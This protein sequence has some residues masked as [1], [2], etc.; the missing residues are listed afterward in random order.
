M[1]LKDTLELIISAD[2]KGAV[3][4]FEEVGASAEK[5]LSK[6][7]SGADRLGASMQKAGGLMIG[8]GAVAV[9]AFG[10]L[11]SEGEKA[12]Q[13]QLKLEQ[14]VQKAGDAAGGSVQPFEDLSHAIADKTEFDHLSVASSEAMQLQVGLTKDQVLKLTPAIADLAAKNGIDLATATDKVTKAVNG[15]K[16]GLESLLG[17]LDAATYATDRYAAV[18]AALDAKVGGFAE[19]QGKTFSGQL[20]IMKN[21]LKDLEEGVGQGAVKAFSSLF[22]AVDTVTGA[23][24]SL[25]PGLQSTIGEWGTFAAVGLVGVGVLTTV[26]GTVMKSVSTLG[27]LAQ[28]LG[29][30]RTAKVA[31]IAVTEAETVANEEMAASM[32]LTPWGMVAIGV[33][34]VAGAFAL[35]SGNAEHFNVD[36]KKMA[37][38]SDGD[39]AASLQ[40]INVVMSMTGTSAYDMGKQLAEQ[41]IPQAERLVTVFGATTEK[42]QAVAR[43]IADVKAEHIKSAE[44]TAIDKQ[45]TDDAT[46]AAQ[47]LNEAEIN[48]VDSIKAKDDALKAELDPLFA[49]I[50]ASNTIMKSHLDVAAAQDKV[51]EAIKKYGAKSPEAVAAQNALNDAQYSGV[52]AAEHFELTL[53]S[54]KTAVASGSVPLTDAKGKLQEWVAE[55]L[56]TQDQAN[57][58]ADAFKAVG[59][60]AGL[61]DGKDV[62]MT[63]STT[64]KNYGAVSGSAS[65]VQTGARAGGGPT[66]AGGFYEVNEYS[67][68]L[69]ETGGHTYLMMGSKGGNVVP[70]GGMSGRGSGG[71]VINLTVNAGMGSDAQQIVDAIRKAIRTTGGA[72]DVQALLGAA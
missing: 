17:P 23:L 11:A 32:A 43:S 28:T 46:L 4:G 48:L 40:K 39:L 24:D 47:G 49:A 22:G 67:P 52:K 72:R 34:V 35:A 54:L 36:A 21:K 61:L 60:Q 26:A 45:A 55:G 8:V 57:K 42:G 56:I 64:Y 33:G 15:K 53:D 13:V 12:T 10:E 62:N 51:T 5:N 2:V 50:D 63:V 68:E 18:Q 41:S 3:K 65:R 29:I 25:S 30:V 27:S 71:T 6:T 38:I 69:L 9:A 16:K 66:A 1:G 58:T 59:I 70:A 19:E 37:E 7:A 44:A 31:D 20:E 14:S